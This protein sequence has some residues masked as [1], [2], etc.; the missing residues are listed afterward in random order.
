MDQSHLK[1]NQEVDTLRGEGGARKDKQELQD[2]K[3]K[4]SRASREASRML[5]MPQQTTSSP[6]PILPSAED[7]DQS[8]RRTIDCD[9]S[10]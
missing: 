1:L 6:A 8:C 3:G 10:I 7:V 5:E 2:E 4:L 9:S